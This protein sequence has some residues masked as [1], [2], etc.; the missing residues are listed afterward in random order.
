MDT[1]SLDQFSRDVANHL[2]AEFPQWQRLATTERA[3]DGTSYLRLE[4]EAP[5]ESSAVSG[6]SL[7]TS[8]G[9]MIVGFDYYHGHFG[10]QL[11][12]GGAE[13]AVRF[14]VDLVNEKIPVVSW[15]EEG[16]L[17]AWSTIEDGRPLLLDDLVGPHDRVRSRSW[18]GRLNVDR[19][20]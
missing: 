4:V 16:E 6:L 7:T 11:G 5:P 18:K 10:G 3:E 9:E 8:D 13:S 12:D 19:D 1:S 17:V 2:F 14:V 15:W 20:A